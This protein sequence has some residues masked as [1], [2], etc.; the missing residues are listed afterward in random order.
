MGSRGRPQL[1]KADRS[2]ESDEFPHVAPVSPA[3]FVVRYSPAILPPEE[4]SLEIR[5][6][7]ED[8]IVGHAVDISHFYL[9]PCPVVKRVIKDVITRKSSGRGMNLR[10]AVII[11]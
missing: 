5:R 6:R 3:G 11:E 10:H 8:D 1:F 4:C 9:V 7:R 2:R